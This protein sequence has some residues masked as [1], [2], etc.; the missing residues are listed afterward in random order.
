MYLQIATLDSTSV[1]IKNYNVSYTDPTTGRVL[2]STIVSTCGEDTCDNDVIPPLSLVCPSSTS[3]STVAITVM[4]YN[5]F[6]QR[7]LTDPITIG[8]LLGSE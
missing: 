7:P 8:M 4:A 3:D 2:D 6:R 5:G 1:F